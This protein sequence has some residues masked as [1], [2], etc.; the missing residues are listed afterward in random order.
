MSALD[1]TTI[2]TV[3]AE[4]VDQRR[5]VCWRYEERKGKRT[6]IPVQPSGRN[7]AVDKPHTWSTLARCRAYAEA[8]PGVGVGIVFNG[9]GLVGSDLDKCR[10]PDTGEITGE[11]RRIVTE[12]N[13]YTE[14]TP[15]GHG[16]HVLCRGELP[17]GA[18][19]TRRGDVEVYATGRFFTVTG[20]HVPDTPD[21]ITN[22]QEA[23]ERLW[24]TLDAPD[25][26]RATNGAADGTS[27]AYQASTDPDT[28]WRRLNTAA[29]A[30]LGGWVPELFGD[31]AK[32]VKGKGGYRIAAT[33]LG[34]D[35]EEDLSIMPHGIRD[36]GMN[37]LGPDRRDYGREGK[38]T[39][40][41]LVLEFGGAP[42]ELHAAVWLAERLDKKLADFGF[43][44]EPKKRGRPR[45][46][47]E[48]HDSEKTQDGN[49]DAHKDGRTL[50]Y[51][52]EEHVNANAGACAR[53]LDEEMFLRGSL[54]AVLVRVEELAG[55]NDDETVTV[56]GV[57]HARGSLILTEPTPERI[58]YR[59]DARA[60]FQRFD[61]KQGKWTPK[62]C[63][64][65]LAR[66]IIGA[67]A[68]LGFRPC[69]GIVAV[70]IFRSRQDRGR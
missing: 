65:A 70:P 12:L 67:A 13:S 5:W 26:R 44:H 14:V 33:D 3:F 38:R 48:H 50:V 30:K 61:L 15:S 55:G 29:L 25:D 20:A 68:E 52:S 21:E 4:L 19:G 10:D 42:D 16:L 63:P 1:L 11:A 6:K 64:P 2:E 53:L 8:I 31:A 59:L 54:P 51:L 58:Q 28:P 45:P 41:D 60:L 17:D 46:N 24:S 34:R 9:D 56:A 69:A 62:S 35:L 22:A 57:R 36:W 39:P 32:F 49:P 43:E 18:T 27:E 47:G 66:R 37:D 40:I 7:A 23:L